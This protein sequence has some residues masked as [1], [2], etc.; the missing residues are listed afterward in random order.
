MPRQYQPLEIKKLSKGFIT[1]VNPLEF[2]A[3]ATIDELN[4]EI[5]K[6]GSRQRR[7]GFDLQEDAIWRGSNQTSD[8]L[9]TQSFLWENAGGIPDKSISVVQIKK[10]LVFFNTDS[11]PLSLGRIYDTTF[12]NAPSKV[13]DFTSVDGLLIVATGEGSVYSFEYKSNDTIERK[14]VRIQIRDI[15]GV[16]AWGDGVNLREE[17]SKSYRPSE[18]TYEHLYNL[19]NQT[20]GLPKAPGDDEASKD[21]IRNFY[22]KSNP[23]RYPSNSDNVLNAFYED[24]AANNPHIKRFYAKDLADSSWGIFDAPRGMFIIDALSRGTSRV[25][26]FNQINSRNPDLIYSLARLPEDRTP[27]GASCVAQF[28]GRV[29][30]GGFSSQVIGGDSQ[31]PKLGSYLFYSKLVNGVADINK[32][33]QESDPTSYE[34]PDLVDTD[35]GYLKVDGAY[36]I[37]RLYNVGSALIVIAEN[38]VWTVSGGSDYGFSATNQKISKVSDRGSINPSSAVLVDNT[39]IF[40]SDDGIYHIRPSQFGDLEAVNI[41]EGT[42]QSYYN[43]LDSVTKATCSGQ[44]DSYEKKVRWLH[45]NSFLEDEG[46]SELVLDVTAGAFVKN[47][48]PDAGGLY[49]VTSSVKV[50][51]FVFTTSQELISYE[52]E[53]VE[54][55]GQDVSIETF[56]AVSASRELLS[57]VVRNGETVSL[58]FGGYFS[59]SFYDWSST[60]SP[61]DSE[62]Y[63]ITGWINGGD[64]IRMKQTPYL[65][66]HFER[67]ETGFYEDGEGGVWPANPS[68]CL[69]RSQWEWSNSPESGKWSRQF[70]AYR[71]KRPYFAAGTQDNYD[72]GDKL[73]VTK[74]KLRGR[75][76]V[77]SLDIRSEPGKDCHIYGWGMVVGV[78]N[79]V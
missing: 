42:I 9:V 2:P 3:D 59:E 69:V 40:W 67:T 72:T 43:N 52:G 60:G 71:Y 1:E 54:Y 31:S 30:Y 17:N 21:P 44:Y 4:F 6:D 66:M 63:L 41:S 50:P 14:A 13:F 79:N 37:S 12:D 61:V 78:N 35:G 49:K 16:D 51:P 73:I 74:N 28:S 58:S 7:K 65:I 23:R 53:A 26:S 70:Q 46:S 22:T 56:G 8:N 34:A 11:S 36:N 57:L 5:N 47:F 39:V 62:A 10:Q 55:E 38:G 27:G 32:C 19:R 68:S 15:F 76:R 29:W 48:I 25:D 20:W 45:S 77:V 33:Y 75:G 24:V 18:M 64:N